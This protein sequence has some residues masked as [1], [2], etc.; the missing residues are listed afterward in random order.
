MVSGGTEVIVG[1]SHDPLFGPV[2]LFGL[3]GIFVEVYEDVA[4]R[5]CPITRSD[6]QEMIQEVK[7]T[8]LL[9][10]FRGLPPADVEA[11]TQILLRISQLG[12]QCEREIQE[13]D[14][15]PLVVLPRGQGVKAVDA[16]VVLAQSSAG[17]SA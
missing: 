11:L 3:G 1:L 17:A 4:L 14:L 2:L 10:G 9:Q 6:A 16:L 8:R 12:M 15:N 7:G 13:L 5:A